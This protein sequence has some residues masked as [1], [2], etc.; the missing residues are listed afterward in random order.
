VTGISIENITFTYCG[1]EVIFEVCA[2]L[3]FNIA[4]IVN[5]SGVTVRNSS[6]FGLHADRVFGSVWVYESAFLYNTGNKEYYGGNVRFWYGE[7]PENHSTHLEIELSYFLHG[8]DTL[9]K[10]HFY[11]PSATTDPCPAIKVNINNVTITGN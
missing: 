4:Y 5:L 9:K 7:C 11:Y 2:A 6:G 10:Y 8:C 3:A 1:H